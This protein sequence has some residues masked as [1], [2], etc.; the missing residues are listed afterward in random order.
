MENVN[1]TAQEYREEYLQKKNKVLSLLDKTIAF[2]QKENVS[3]KIEG[4]SNLRKNVENGVFSI[5]VVGEFSAGKSTFLNALMKKRILPSF[6]NETTAT[7]NFLRHKEHAEN[8]TAGQVFYYDGTVKN[9]ENTNL[10]TV[11]KYVSTK[12][13]NVT[14][15]IQH[16]DLYLDSDFH[17]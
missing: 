7:V 15:E 5:V 13:D 11:E 8:G 3:D 1:K 14:S 17:V 10:E 2:Y 12:G 16:L 9:L 6:S 4:F